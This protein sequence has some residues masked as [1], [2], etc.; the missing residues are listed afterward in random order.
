MPTTQ[1][2]LDARLQKGW[3]HA[4]EKEAKLRLKWFRANEARLNEIANKPPS[5]EVPEDVKNEYKK[6]LIESYQNV[7]KHPRIKTRD[8][9]PIDP[10]AFQGIMKPVDPAVRKL[11]YT[12]SNK[13]G[14]M[15]YLKK[16]VELIPERRFYFTEV[17]SW[18][19]GW[20][21]WDSAKDMRKT[22]FGRQQVIKDSFYRRRGVGNDPE[23]Y[24]EPAV[25]SPSICSCS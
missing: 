7:I 12:G 15:N 16:R 22:G 4:I 1:R 10:S 24:K 18:E 2:G 20:N 8:P 13:D 6:T 9:D 19:Y 23:W 21:M 11:I 3:A 25:F 14:R 5:R 17:S